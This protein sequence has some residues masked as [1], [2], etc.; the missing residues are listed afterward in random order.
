MGDGGETYYAYSEGNY[1]NNLS[2]SFPGQ[3]KATFTMDLIGT[4]TQPPTIT[5]VTGAENKLDPAGTSA[6][7]TTSDFARLRIQKTD[8]TGISTDFK[9]MDISIDNNVSPEKVLAVLGARFMNLGNFTVANSVEILMTSSGV[10]EAVRNNTTTTM[11]S[12]I[13]NDDGAIMFDFPSATMG[14]GA[15]AFPVDESVTIS[16]EIKSY[17]DDVLG[18]SLGVSMFPSVPEYG[19]Y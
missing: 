2:L 17:G 13:Q 6:F 16:S 3:D 11:D 12:C 15:P 5:R 1:F 10:A 18:T 8:E 9:S 14:G 19:N 7:N 4:D